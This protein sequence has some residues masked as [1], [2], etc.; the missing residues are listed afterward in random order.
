[1]RSIGNNGEDQA[2]KYLVESG[3]DI[4]KRNYY[5]RFGELDII[6]QKGKQLHIIEVKYTNQFYI[7]SIYKLN[8]KKI[9]RMI[10]SS[11]VFLDRMKLEGV[12]V[13]FD[14]IAI[15][16]DQINHHKNIFSLT[17]I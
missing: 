10:R 11:Q 3:F 17:D 13:Q 4:K 15:V 2:C 7:D 6:A 14:L 8:R 1:M 12:Y 16:G 9:K 5:T